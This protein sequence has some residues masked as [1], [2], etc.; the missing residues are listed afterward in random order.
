MKKLGISALL[1]L[2][3]MLI[4]PV[5]ASADV[6]FPAPEPFVAGEEVNHLL[7]TLDPEGSV[8]TDPALLPEGLHL[9][10]EVTEEGVSVYLRGVPTVPGSYDLLFNY[11]GTDSICTVTVLPAPE[12][13]PAPVPVSLSVETPPLKTA[14][15]A[16]DV[17]DPAGLSLLVEWSSGEHSQISEGYAL[18]PTRLDQAGT[19]S[20]EVNYEGLLCY[21]Q[22]EVAAAPEVIEGIGILS[23]P[24]RVVYDLGEELDPR[25]LSIRVYTNNGTRD[26]DEDLLCTPT[27]LTDP[28]PQEITVFY[29]DHSCFFNVQVQEAEAPASIAVFRM[30]DKVDFTQGEPLDTEGLVLV[31][32]SNRDNPS[33]VTEGWSCKPDLLEEPGRQEITVTLGELSCSYYVTVHAAPASP[34][35]S[36]PPA[37][38][39]PFPAPQAP[40]VPTS[41]VIQPLP[42]RIPSRAGDTQTGSGGHLAL[43]LVLASLAALAVLA[44]YV[45][46][47]NRSAGQE[48]LAT[49]KDFFR[50]RR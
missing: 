1:L 26:V 7:A 10:T 24:N 5:T 14:Y 3:L 38:V 8:T 49:V 21:F 25:G 42:E 22:V 6:I 45:L 35:P 27:R 16:G 29:G 30:P 46:V 39:A 15:T 50:Y 19:V 37:T 12:P 44:L 47:I 33:Y 34:A 36:A 31:E 23:L 28:G 32:T 18:Y 40:A 20:V 43:I 2:A 9:E 4:I 48:L 13:E 17:L 11:N 41:V